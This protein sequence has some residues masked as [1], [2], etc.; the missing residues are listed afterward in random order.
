MYI[1]YNIGNKGLRPQVSSRL[2]LF[3]FYIFYILIAVFREKSL[4]SENFPFFPQIIAEYCGFFSKI[5]VDLKVLH[6]FKSQK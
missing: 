6:T 5:Y 1:A 4:Q 3:N 2:I